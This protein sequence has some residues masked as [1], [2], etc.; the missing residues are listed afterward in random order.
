MIGIK[1]TGASDFVERYGKAL[2]DRL[3]QA[4]EVSAR[5]L[6][7]TAR[8][9]VPVDTGELRSSV[10][11]V[12]KKYSG[13]GQAH[14]AA[15]RRAAFSDR[16]RNSAHGT[17]EAGASPVASIIQG[18]QEVFSGGTIARPESPFDAFVFASANHAKYVEYGTS[19][20]PARF[21]LTR[22]S[23]AHKPVHKMLLIGAIRQAHRDA[24]RRKVRRGLP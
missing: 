8:V 20:M 24:D 2:T 23:L 15:V 17:A 22:A 16:R 4:T 1:V 19:R 10:H 7:D 12:T 18:R 5:Q 3:E 14:R 21:P 11:A 6:R 13:F 9:F